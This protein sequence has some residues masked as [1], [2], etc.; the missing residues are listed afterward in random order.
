MPRAIVPPTAVLA[1]ILA[2]GCSVTP[3][4]DPIAEMHAIRALDSRFSAAVARLDVV[5]TAALYAPDATI[6]P[7]GLPA[8]HGA[9]AIR[10]MLASLFTAPGLSITLRPQRIDIAAAGDLATDQGEVEVGMNTA[11]GPVI[12]VSKYLE[13]WR[14]VDGEWKL[15]YD[16]WNANEPVAPATAATRKR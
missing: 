8:V 6:L 1:M 13:V 10:T 7:P 3:K 11:E 9:D 5:G 2:A 4:V 16:T 12:E 14:K 15:M